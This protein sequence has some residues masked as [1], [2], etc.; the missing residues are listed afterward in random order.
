MGTDGCWQLFRATRLWSLLLLSAR[1]THCWIPPAELHN[2]PAVVSSP[3]VG[4]L[5][6][7][8]FQYFSTT[9][10]QRQYGYRR[11]WEPAITIADEM[12]VAGCCGMS[13][14]LASFSF[15]F[16]SFV[17]FFWRHHFSLPHSPSAVHNIIEKIKIKKPANNNNILAG[18]RPPPSLRWEEVD[19]CCYSNDFNY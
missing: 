17:L 1:K 14:S 11:D 2:G 8:L 10:E 4:T 19:F 6:S 16:F 3:R 7:Q 13:S 9:V 12:D 5:N 15:F 18:R